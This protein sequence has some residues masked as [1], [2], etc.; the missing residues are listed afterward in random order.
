MKFFATVAAS[1]LVCAQ[2]GLAAPTAAVDLATRAPKNLTLIAW[3]EAAMR[4]NYDVSLSDAQYDKAFEATWGQNVTL[5]ANGRT[6]LTRPS[7]KAAIAGSK[8]NAT[9]IE[10]VFRDVIAFQPTPGDESTGIVAGT[11]ITI[12]SHGSAPKTATQTIFINGV[13]PDSSVT[14]ADKRRIVTDDTVTVAIASG[15]K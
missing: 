8:A 13:A 3:F 5:Q 2:I 14:T 12:S 4:S 11:L 6:G 7:L 1:L 9:K 15:R 10:L